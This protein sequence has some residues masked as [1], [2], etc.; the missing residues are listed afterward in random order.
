MDDYYVLNRSGTFSTVGKYGCGSGGVC[1]ANMMGLSKN[2][3]IN[4]LDKTFY[5]KTTMTEFIFPEKSPN[6]N[7]TLNDSGIITFNNSDEKYFEISCIVSM[8][9]YNLE[10]SASS[11]I[12]QLQKLDGLSWKPGVSTS[13]YIGESVRNIPF[14]LTCIDKFKKG[15]TLRLIGVGTM[16]KVYV[17]NKDATLPNMSIN[18]S[19]REFPFT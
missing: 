18:I 5:N 4:L 12:V 17:K 6:T 2:H 15:D 8:F 1:S 7:I 10:V 13:N 16:D 3:Q 9:I 19:I 14:S 11:Y